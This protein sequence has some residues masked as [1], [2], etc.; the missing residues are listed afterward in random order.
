MRT[1]RKQTYDDFRR[2]IKCVDPVYYRWGEGK[3]SDM[4]PPRRFASLVLG[5][6]CAYIVVTI[7]NNRVLLENSLRQGTLPED[8]QSQILMALSALLAISLVMVGLHLLRFLLLRKGGKK[9]NSGA[10]LAGVIGALTL[11]HMPP[12]VWYKGLG[13]MDVD[14][15]AL[16]LTAS[17]RVEDAIGVDFGQAVF[18][19]SQGQ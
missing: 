4:T 1:F 6:I 13:M 5:F 15:R 18:V 19:S 11:I 2:R 12:S 8:T 10:V 17:A 14:G 16:M 9:S 3:R 7:S